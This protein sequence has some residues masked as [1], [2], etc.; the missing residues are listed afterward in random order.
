MKELEQFQDF[1]S[2]DKAGVEV[3][4]TSCLL[5]NHIYL[6]K[7]FI[8]RRQRQFTVDGVRSGSQSVKCHDS[9]PIL[10]LMPPPAEAVPRTNVNKS[11]DPEAE[12]EKIQHRLNDMGV[13][14]ADYK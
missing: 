6:V 9:P 10:G 4:A 2:S 14:E 7:E 1:N 12:E 5:R 13:Y 8:Q 11:M 3:A